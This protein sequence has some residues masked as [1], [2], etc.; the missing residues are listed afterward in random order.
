MRVRPGRLD[1]VLLLEPTPFVD[2]R[3][4][5][6]RTLDAEVLREAGVDPGGFVQESQSRSGRHVLRG[7]HFRAAPGE[8]KLVR[9]ARGG[10]LDVV[11]DL[12]PWSATFGQWEG[13]EL[14]DEVHRHLYVP[15]GFGHGFQVLSEVADVCYHH[16]AS[17]DAGGEMVL[18]WDDPDVGV[19][20]PHPPQSLSGRDQQ[21]PS[22]AELLPRLRAWFPG[23]A[24]SPPLA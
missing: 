7:L 13:F 20:W 15:R 21:A 10:I 23:P 12:R 3:G 4:F 5:F 9:C 1:G 24:Q 6:V 18:A 11:V 19:A 8:A 22:L 14:D 17:Y 2:D 16:D